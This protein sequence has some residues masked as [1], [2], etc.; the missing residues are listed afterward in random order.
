[1]L[2]KTSPDK[3]KPRF[4]HLIRSPGS[5][6]IGRHHHVN[7][8]QN[9]AVI[10]P[11]GRHDALVTHQIAC[12]GG[13]QV[14]EERLQLRGI[15]RPLAPE[16]ERLHRIVVLVVILPKEAGFALKNAVK[17]EAADVDYRGYRRVAEM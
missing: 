9:H 13:D 17:R 1:V 6:G 11:G 10:E 15:K 12:M 2:W 3:Y 5:I 4:P 7:T 14:A 16:R 8:L